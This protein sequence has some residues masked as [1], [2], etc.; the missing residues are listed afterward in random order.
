MH[1]CAPSSRHSQQSFVDASSCGCTVP[2]RA[3]PASPQPGAAP[4]TPLHL[5]QE[6]TK[7]INRNNEST[8][9]SKAEQ[10]GG[11]LKMVRSREGSQRLSPGCSS[12]RVPG[13]RGSG[14]P[15]VAWRAPRL[16]CCSVG[17]ES[18]QSASRPAHGGPRSRRR[19][20]WCRQTRRRGTR[21]PSRRTRPRTPE[22]V[23][24]GAYDCALNPCRCD[25]RRVD[26]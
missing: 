1:S 22:G 9:A 20:S 24:F 8:F 26:P 16:C 13:L 19:P 3:S 15:P 12:R 7:M 23:P 5:L 4:N 18:P 14:R 11:Q 17:G 21:P 2:R 10:S 25:T 6:L